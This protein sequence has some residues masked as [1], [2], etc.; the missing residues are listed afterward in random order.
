MRIKELEK[1]LGVELFKRGGRGASLTDAGRIAADY[2]ARVMIVLSEMRLAIDQFKGFQ[3]GQ[4]R[5]GATTTIAVHLLPKA[6]VHFKKR[7]PE[8]EIR[9]MVCRTTEI[10]K[11]ILADDL[12]VGLVAGSLK[13]SSAFNVLY[14]LTD[15]FVV[16][17]PPNHSFAKCE[18][19]SLKQI[20]KH[21]LIIR[22]KGSF[23]RLILDESFRA[24]GITYNCVMEIETSEAVKKAVAEGLGCSIAPLCS[25]QLEKQTGNLAYARIVGAPMKRDFRA[26]VHKDRK[27][28]GPVQPFLDI[29]NEIE[30]ES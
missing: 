28:F 11:R 2:T 1:E 29:L 3:R 4:L 7:L 17:T 25:I 19:V 6:L 24:A 9:M 23:P 26:I 22:E 8:V 12:D 13:N 16:I 20:A 27:L 5:C 21:P 15:E 18:R 14:F 30:V 10:E